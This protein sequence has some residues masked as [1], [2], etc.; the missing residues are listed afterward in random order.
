MN[1]KYLIA[2]ILIVIPF[3]VYFAIPTYNRVN[4]EIG[5]LTFFYWYQTLWL[6][7]SA[8]LFGIAAYILDREVKQ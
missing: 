1:T 7:I 6:G 5:G 2:G 4:P 3:I 8:L